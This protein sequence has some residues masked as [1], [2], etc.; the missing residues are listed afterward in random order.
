MVP[1]TDQE[2]GPLDDEEQQGA[3]GT[4]PFAAT[5]AISADLAAVAELACPRRVRRKL[6]KKP[7]L[8]EEPRGID[9]PAAPP[10]HPLATAGSCTPSAVTTSQ[11]DQAF[12][13]CSRC[14][15]VLVMQF[16]NGGT[17]VLQCPNCLE[18]MHV[19]PKQC[20]PAGKKHF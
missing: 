15:L 7:N 18:V 13:R 11:P 14:S 5:A 2:H 4:A 10:R 9:T 16:H 17:Q 3:A 6:D 19:E 20:S 8:R 1:A 12:L